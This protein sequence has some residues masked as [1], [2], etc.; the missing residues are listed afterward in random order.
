MKC[1]DLC[2]RERSLAMGGTALWKGRRTTKKKTK[3]TRKLTLLKAPTFDRTKPK[4]LS[5]GVKVLHHLD[6]RSPPTCIFSLRPTVCLPQ[7]LHPVSVAGASR[8]S[9][10]NI[11]KYFPLLHPAKPQ[12]PL[13]SPPSFSPVPRSALPYTCAAFPAGTATGDAAGAKSSPRARTL[14]SA[15]HKP[16]R[17]H[18]AQ[19]RRKGVSTHLTGTAFS[20]MHLDMCMC[21][22]VRVHT[23]MCAWVCACVPIR[24]CE[25]V[26]VCVCTSTC[27]C[28]CICVFAC[29]HIC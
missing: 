4:F 14:P 26:H 24:T 12:M 1:L 16:L 28:I 27:A 10:P 6:P 29:V 23:S 8:Q 3:R 9:S 15:G 17:P 13:K 18:R 19:R 20:L 7:Y 11:H 25:C 5:V 22:W 21:V 2:G